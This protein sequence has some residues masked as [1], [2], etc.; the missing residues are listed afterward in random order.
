MKDRDSVPASNG[1]APGLRELHGACQRC[2]CLAMQRRFKAEGRNV[3]LSAIER[4][5]LGKG[6]CLKWICVFDGPD[7]CP[8]YYSKYDEKWSSR[9][10]A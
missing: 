5:N 7:A 10:N 1:E 2:N 3:R 8:G 6:G 9:N 4:N